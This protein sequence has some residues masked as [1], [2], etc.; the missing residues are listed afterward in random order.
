CRS[1]AEVGDTNDE[2]FRAGVGDRRDR[3]SDITDYGVDLLL[4]GAAGKR[5]VIDLVV[6]AAGP[7]IVV[8]DVNDYIIDFPFSYLLSQPPLLAL[9][10]CSPGAGPGPIVFVA[11]APGLTSRAPRS[12]VHV[13]QPR[14]N[15]DP[16]ERNLGICTAAIVVGAVF[17]GIAI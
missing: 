3:A 10:I 2:H 1:Y 5:T 14:K 15:L 12:H 6:G 9:E 11:R 17:V 7:K 13:S 16:I 8:A 4:Q